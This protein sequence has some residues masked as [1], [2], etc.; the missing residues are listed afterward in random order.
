MVDGRGA[1][2]GGGG[3]E[4]EEEEEEEEEGKPIPVEGEW[5][6]RLDKGGL[7]LG[8]RWFAGGVKAR[9]AERKAR[10]VLREGR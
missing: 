6:A 7:V 10:S 8:L 1:G 5:V 2:R 9:D 3:G 4:E